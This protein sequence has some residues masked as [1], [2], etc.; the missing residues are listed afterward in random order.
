M[1]EYEIKFWEDY[2]NAD[3]LKRLDLVKNLPLRK[4]LRDMESIDDKKITEEMKSQMIAQLLNGYFEDMIDAV[5]TKI[6]VENRK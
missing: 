5:H 3:C 2:L 6:D 4:M 1:S